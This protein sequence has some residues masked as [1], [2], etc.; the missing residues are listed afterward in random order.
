MNPACDT[1]PY[2]VLLT[3]VPVFMSRP[4]LN[5]R[6]VS[7]SHLCKCSMRNNWCSWWQQHCSSTKTS[8]LSIQNEKHSRR[9]LILI[10]LL[11]R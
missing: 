2:L 10:N 5:C 6:L 9:Y 1:R 8:K 3:G 11:D 4:F 7:V